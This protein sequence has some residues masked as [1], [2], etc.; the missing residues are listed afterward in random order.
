MQSATRY[1]RPGPGD[2]RRSSSRLL[3]PA[4][5]RYLEVSADIARQVDA[6]GYQPDAEL[7]SI[8]S[9][10]REQGT[11]AATVNRAYRHL[12]AHGVV[13]IGA[14]RRARVAPD[15]VLAARRLLGT[16][17]V[18]R[19]SRSDDP[20]LD[21]VLRQA[22]PAVRTVGERGSFPALAA[23]SQGTADGA[24]IHLLHHSGHYNSPFAAT[25]LRGREPTLIR[26]WRR[27][28]GLL[29]PGGNPE[30]IRG[31][32]DLE[33]R[34]VAR[35]G[36]GSGSR[37]LADRLLIDAGLEPDTVPGPDVASHLEVGLAVATGQADAGFAVRS[38]AVDLGLSFVPL[39]WERFDLV[40]P[41]AALAAAGPLL[42]AVRAAAVR[43]A[44]AALDGYD[45]AGAGTVEAV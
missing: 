25:L 29:V 42:D 37:V 8:R 23:L 14:R 6:G 3:S 34:R 18:F 15:G 38:V 12:A 19:L 17:R 4:V 20:A 9:L 21:L 5:T 26:L 22:G 36:F 10:A 45:P 43:T 32:G 30:G 27:E 16:Q 33:G 44:I 7:P 24:A 2:E 40:L 41:G 31:P 1:R 39:H 11:T 35:R 28:Q 13:A